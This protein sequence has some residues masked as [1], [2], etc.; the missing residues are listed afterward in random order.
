M[1]NYLVAQSHILCIDD[2]AA[3]LKL[4]DRM[5]RAEGYQQ[6]TLI[7]DP[8]EVLAQYHASRPDL[9]LLDIN[10]PHLDGYQ[11]MAQLLALEDPLMPPI[12]ILTAQNNHDFLLKALA[13]GA[14]DFISKPFDRV[15]LLMR[16]RNLLF[17]HL[18]H[19]MLHDQN[20]VLE[21]MVSQRT[22]ALQQSRLQVVQ[23]LGRAAEYRDNETG[24]HVIRMSHF[25]ATLAAAL[26]WSA[27]QCEL[28][29]HASPMHDVG[30]IG[31]ADAIL[32]KPG[33]LDAH[34]WSIMQ[35]HSAIG[36]DI[37]ANA[38]SELLQLA[39]VIAESHHEKWD[40]SGYPHGLAG[41]EIPQAARIVAVADVFDALTSKRPYKEAWPV[42]SAVQ[43]MTE[44]SGS[45]FDPAI[46][47][48]FLQQLPALLEIRAR[49]VE[50][51]ATDVENV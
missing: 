50:P 27:P 41:E 47:A 29:L 26:G 9:I 33:K 42:D 25:S 6:L 13:Q 39:R 45:H 48:V 14:R 10:M 43:W 30:K 49:H 11:V 16:V 34:E 18:A 7:A 4:L 5:L 31:I 22:E 12:V 24:Q 44:Q 20:T 51:R 8:R 2:E 38:D 1:N 21:E 35:Q 36:A 3:N 28:L 37:L 23:R 46:I 32:L 40:G 19:R 17:A 15:E